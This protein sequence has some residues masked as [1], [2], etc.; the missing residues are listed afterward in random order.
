[1]RRSCRA[2]SPSRNLLRFSF[3]TV[4]RGR[5]HALRWLRQ[6][7]E[8]KIA[9]RRLARAANC[10]NEYLELNRHVPQRSVP[11]HSAEVSRSSGLPGSDTDVAGGTIAVK[12][13]A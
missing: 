2:P 5:S 1:M 13:R 8:G 10:S 4:G 3:H 9:D 6:D 11:R 12:G 7:R